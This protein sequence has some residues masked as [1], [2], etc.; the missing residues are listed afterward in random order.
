MKSLLQD[1]ML[2]VLFALLGAYCFG[3][4]LFLVPLLLD[5]SHL[6][7]EQNL[8]GLLLGL[9]SLPFFLFASTWWAV[10]PTGALLG[11]LIAQ[12]ARDKPPLRAAATGAVFAML[13]GFPLTLAVG[14]ILHAQYIYI[15][16]FVV[17]AFM[18]PFGAAYGLLAVLLHD[19]RGRIGAA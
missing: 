3:L 11:V 14:W 12:V 7:S 9:A 6:E 2:G 17:A 13:A 18:T 10:L 5:G 16:M 8:F 15:W 19:R 1:S 4:A